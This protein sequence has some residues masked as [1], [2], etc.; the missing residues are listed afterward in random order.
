MWLD[1]VGNPLNE[2]I[3]TSTNVTFKLKFY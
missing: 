1:P 2:I 3:V